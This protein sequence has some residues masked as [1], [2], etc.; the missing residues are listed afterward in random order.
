MPKKKTLLI[1]ESNLF[2]TLFMVCSM[3]VWSALRTDLCCLQINRNTGG[4]LFP[5]GSHS[6]PQTPQPPPPKFLGISQCKAG[7]PSC[8]ELGGASHTFQNAT[9]DCTVKLYGKLLSFILFKAISAPNMQNLWFQK[10]Y[11]ICRFSCYLRITLEGN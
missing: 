6:S 3:R 11:L 2:A 5:T 7:N 4:S 10:S 1:R 9:G 8:P